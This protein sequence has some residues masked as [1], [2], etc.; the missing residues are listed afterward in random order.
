[1]RFIYLMEDSL[2]LRQFDTKMKK[3]VTIIPESSNKIQN[4]PFEKNIELLEKKSRN[5]KISSH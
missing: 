5:I 1:M 4:S 3:W 2:K